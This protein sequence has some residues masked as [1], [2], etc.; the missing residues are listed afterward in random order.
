[1]FSV[2]RLKA[3]VLLI[4]LSVEGEV[5]GLVRLDLGTAGFLVVS[6]TVVVVDRSRLRRDHSVLLN[7]LVF[8]LYLCFSRRDLT[9]VGRL[10]LIQSAIS[11]HGLIFVTFFNDI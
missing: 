1:M 8:S 4:E 3:V 11:L 2:G 10:G 6:S 9:T 7:L 5:L